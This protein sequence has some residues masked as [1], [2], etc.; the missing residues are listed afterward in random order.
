[1]SPREEQYIT[2]DEGML[3]DDKTQ[4]FS[5]PTTEPIIEP[6]TPEPI[7]EPLKPNPSSG[8]RFMDSRTFSLTP[9]R[10]ESAFQ[11]H[12]PEREEQYLEDEPC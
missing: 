3:D 9:R 10:D 2:F 12:R 7:I 8:S 4:I 5:V 1:M 11:L 6:F